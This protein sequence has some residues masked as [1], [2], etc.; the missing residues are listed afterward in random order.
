MA[1]RKTSV[2]GK[3]AS[4][5]GSDGSEGK[6]GDNDGSKHVKPMAFFNGMRQKLLPSTYLHGGLR[7]YRSIEVQI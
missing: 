7:H 5:D 1:V 6:S 3:D 4:S 2:V